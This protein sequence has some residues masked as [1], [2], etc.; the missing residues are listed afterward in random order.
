MM[1]FISGL[2][3]ILLIGGGLPA[4]AQSDCQ[5]PIAPA[6]PDG[7]TSTQAQLMAAA[8]DARSF[9]AQSDVY[10]QCLAD[11]VKAQ[12]DLAIK[13]KTPF[14]NSIQ[15]DAL[16]KI[17]E[18]QDEKVKVGGDINAAIGAFKASHPQ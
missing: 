17:S 1:R 11:Y 4:A 18:N 12:R 3:F 16:K 8:G 2:A 9:I 10:Q 13:N 15:T 6:A 14:D 5:M 7:K